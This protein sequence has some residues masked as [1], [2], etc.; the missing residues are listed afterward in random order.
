MRTWI[1]RTIGLLGLCLLLLGGT[2]AS[3]TPSYLL[4][5]NF[6]TLSGDSNALTVRGTV[7]NFTGRTFDAQTYLE[8]IYNG[9]PILVD[10]GLLA[11]KSSRAFSQTVS[12][13][14]PQATATSVL[15]HVIAGLP[16]GKSANHFASPCI[17][18]F[19]RLP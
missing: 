9:Q 18:S 19:T 6:T 14:A 13:S 11:T 4:V 15:F 12:S 16:G 7:T 17:V 1:A 8:I 3:A 5:Q 2:R 10:I